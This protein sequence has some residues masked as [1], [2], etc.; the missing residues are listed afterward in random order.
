MEIMTYSM[1]LIE[2]STAILLIL[3]AGNMLWFVCLL[4]PDAGMPCQKMAEA[5]RVDKGS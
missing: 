4:S 3:Y 2:A 1:G 5:G